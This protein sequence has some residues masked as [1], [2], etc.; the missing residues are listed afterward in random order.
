[1]TATAARITFIDAD[2]PGLMHALQV[3]PKLLTLHADRPFNAHQTAGVVLSL[4][5]AG[6]V[7]QNSIERHREVS[8]AFFHDRGLR[9]LIKENRC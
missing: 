1:M 3:E 8:A 7:K 2:V 6:E 9:A 4:T 5:H